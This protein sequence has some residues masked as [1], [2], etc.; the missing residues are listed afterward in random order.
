MLQATCTL[1]GVCLLAT[2]FSFLGSNRYPVTKAQFIQK[3]GCVEMCN[4]HMAALTFNTGH[5]IKARTHACIEIAHFPSWCIIRTWKALGLW[6]HASQALMVHLVGKCANSAR[7]WVL[8]ILHTISLY[9]W[10]T[11]DPSSTLPAWV[12]WQG[13]LMWVSHFSSYKLKN[14]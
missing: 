7:A 13:W 6:S 12:F 5:V 1:F 10:P 4:F 14:K 8:A 9:K 3:N 2:I 11:N